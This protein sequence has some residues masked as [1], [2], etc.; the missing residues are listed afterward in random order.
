[1]SINSAENH[2]ASSSKIF[3][4]YSVSEGSS[5][6]L[7]E[8]M[9]I[10]R[11]KEGYNDLNNYSS[12]SWSKPYKVP[13]SAVRSKVDKIHGDMQQLLIALESMLEK[14]YIN[15]FLDSDIEECHY[16]L[17]QELRKSNPNLFENKT[18]DDG[19]IYGGGSGNFDETTGEYINEVKI[20]DPDYV[21]FSQYLYAEEHGCRSCRKFVKEYDRLIS[22]SV[23]V[24]LF[25]FRYYVKLLLHESSCIKESL[26]Y[27]FGEDYEDESQQ[28]AAQFYFSWAKMA[29]NHSRLITEELNSKTDSIATSEVDNISKKQAAQFQAFFSIRVASYT[30]AIDNLLFSLKKDLED[31][32]EIF[33]KRFVAPSLRFK[34]KVSAPL[35]LD[36]L[37]TSLGTAA[38]ILSEEVITAVNAFR[39][40]FGSIL[41]DMVQRRNNV[42]SK[43]DN[44]LSFNIQRKKYINYIDSLASK[45]SSRPKIILI[46][47]EDKTSDIFASIFIDKSKRDSLK[48]SH[49]SL[50]ELDKDS[51]PQ[52]LLRGGGNIFGDITVAEGVT[53]DGVDLDQHAHTGADGTVRIKSTDIDYDTV[54]EETTLLETEEGS[55]LQVSIDSFLS[56]IK[57][58]GMPTTDAI[59]LISIPDE[60]QDKY[61]FEIMYVEN[62]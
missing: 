38:P 33:Y 12:Y 9:Q 44:L 19:L 29:E 8:E 58:G 61:E 34:T 26:L 39:G 14:V 13:I 46:N 40:N 62:K 25:D 18:T 27:D 52:Y 7:S 37:T 42:Q 22:H 20:E 10:K 16:H 51:H 60:F 1:M 2:Q 54:R 32:C 45:A 11:T 41:T 17:W 56:S 21:S 59:V 43:F 5:S 3:N 6:S 24:H 36:L 4:D 35:E 47:V 48:S 28:Q 57:Q 50:D 23:F 31:T 49:D 15:P 30:E 55:L 53:I